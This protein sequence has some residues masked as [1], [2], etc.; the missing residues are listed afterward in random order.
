MR[1]YVVSDV[2]GGAAALAAAAG[3]GDAFICLGNLL[4][5]VDYADHRRGIFADL[6]G[7]RKPRSSIGLR[8]GEAIRR[9]P[10]DLPAA[11]GGPGR[12][13]GAAGGEGGG[14]AV[15]RAVR[16]HAGARLASPTATWTAPDVGRAPAPGIRCSTAADRAGRL[17]IRVRRR[18]APLAVP[19]AERDG[20]GSVAAKVAAVGRWT[21][22]A[23]T[24]RRTCP[25]ALRHG[26][27]PGRGGQHGAA[28]ADPGSPSRATRC[29]ATFTSRWSAGSGSAGPSASTLGTSAPPAS[30]SCCTGSPPGPGR[31]GHAGAPGGRAYAPVMADSTT[32]RISIVGGQAGR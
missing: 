11:M 19:D 8:P 2:H 29:S 27:P 20:R 6:F 12:R 31:C 7:T 22:C 4:L 10:G 30:R 28:R 13:P 24:S 17:E 14:P 9:G 26:G 3:G 23:A 1:V 15:R 32:S 18:R 21:C 16:G 5:F 25:A